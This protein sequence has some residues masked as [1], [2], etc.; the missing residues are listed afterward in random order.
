MSSLQLTLSVQRD[1]VVRRDAV[2]DITLSVRSDDLPAALRAR[3]AADLRPNP[4]Q[5]LSLDFL[6]TRCAEQ[7]VRLLALVPGVMH[8]Y[9]GVNESG[10]TTRRFAFQRDEPVDTAPPQDVASALHAAANDGAPLPSN[11][12]QR[13]ND[14]GPSQRSTPLQQGCQL[15]NPQH[16]SATDGTPTAGAIGVQPGAVGRGATQQ[17]TGCSD[18]G[19]SSAASVRVEE[20]TLPL[21]AV[22]AAVACELERVKSIYGKEFTCPAAGPLPELPQRSAGPGGVDP[23]ATCSLKLP[24]SDPD[25][26]HGMVSV[27]A[28]VQ[29]A[30]AVSTD[31]GN[32]ISA[33][34]TGLV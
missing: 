26:Q 28:H 31:V 29:L 22:P 14:V 18:A 13:L 7:F 24:L 20:G 32:S 8:A 5:T 23:A 3:I 30:P 1:V 6:F 16:A 15:T 25:W 34:E 17:T 10:G 27:W 21:G 4:L 33:W 11:A 2:L 9:E 19:A 12:P